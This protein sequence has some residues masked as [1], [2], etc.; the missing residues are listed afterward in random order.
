MKSS[1]TFLEVPPK[2]PT[3]SHSL[4]ECSMQG[5]WRHVA[6]IGTSSPCC[7][8]LDLGLVCK[9]LSKLQPLILGP[10]PNLDLRLEP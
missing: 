7:R 3:D 4:L 1:L 2:N 8:N 5:L 6:K 9:S 10:S